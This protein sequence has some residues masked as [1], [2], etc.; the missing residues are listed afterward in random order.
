MSVSISRPVSGT[1]AR[2]PPSPRDEGPSVPSLP[3][4]C[5]SVGMKW[6][7]SSG[8]SPP[9]PHP[10]A[11][12]SWSASQGGWSGATTHHPYGLLSRDHPSCSGEAGL[13]PGDGREV[14]EWLPQQRGWVSGFCNKRSI[15]RHSCWRSCHVS[16]ALAFPRQLQITTEL[17]SRAR[18]A[19]EME[20]RV[21]RGRRTCPQEDNV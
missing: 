18:N 1:A 2:K 11:A 14:P 4:T 3:Q 5:G 10:P 19:M 15:P 6:P 12:L 9:L 7:E 21:A 8:A 20:L 17:T 16:P 13:S